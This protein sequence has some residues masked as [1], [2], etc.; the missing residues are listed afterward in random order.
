MKSLKMFH[1]IAPPAT[2]PYTPGPLCGSQTSKDSTYDT[3]CMSNSSLNCN[4]MSPPLSAAK[5]QDHFHASMCHLKSYNSGCGYSDF[6]T[7]DVNFPDFSH[8]TF[9]NAETPTSIYG[10]SCG[11]GN[12]L[13]FEAQ[14]PSINYDD[15]DPTLKRHSMGSCYEEDV[16]YESAN[17][18]VIHTPHSSFNREDVFR[19]EPEDIARL[20]ENCQ[21]E[22]GTGEGSSHMMV[23][24]TPFTPQTPYTPYPATYMSF[25]P[26]SSGQQQQMEY[27]QAGGVYQQEPQTSAQALAQ[28]QQQQ[29]MAECPGY[30]L[31]IE[32]YNYDEINCQSKEQSPCSSPP[33]D[34]WMSL[35]LNENPQQPA[36]QESPKIINTSYEATNYQPSYEPSIKQEHP[37]KLPSMMSTFGTP[38]YEPLNSFSYNEYEMSQQ[39]S[40]HVY[41]PPSQNHCNGTTHNYTPSS[42]YN[43]FNALT[44]DFENCNMLNLEKPNRD[45]KVI[46]TIDELDEINDFTNP[47]MMMANQQNSYFNQSIER[48]DEE[49]EEEEEEG[50][51]HYGEILGHE[52]EEEVFAAAATLD[53]NDEVF[54]VEKPKTV[55]Q[56][57]KRSSNCRS[58]TAS[59]Q[60]VPCEEALVDFVQGPMVCLWTDCNEEFPNQAEFVCHI[61]KKHV[62]VKR[63]EDFSCFWVDCPRRYKPFNAR[64]KLL[65]HMRV[66][67]GEKPNKCPFPGCNKAFS[68]LENLKIH[69]RSHTGERPYGCQYKGCLK[70]FSNSSDRAKHQR[71]HYDTKPYACQLPGC[72][73][74]YTDPSSLRKH[75]KNHA[76]R[77][78]NGHLG[79]RKSTTAAAAK[80]TTATT[81]TR[82]HSESSLMQ[83]KPLG[84][85]KIPAKPLNNAVAKPRSNSCSEMSLANTNYQE[86]QK[87]NMYNTTATT[88]TNLQQQQNMLND[89]QLQLA[90]TIAAANRNSMNFNE[91]SNCLV[92]IEQHNRAED[93]GVEFAA[94]AT[95]NLSCA[96]NRRNSSDSVISNSSNGSHLSNASIQ[97]IN[98]FQ[99]MLQQQQQQQQQLHATSNGQQQNE[100][101]TNLV[102]TT[103]CDMLQSAT[104]S[105]SGQQQQQE[106]QSATTPNI[107]TTIANSCESNSTD[108]AEYVSFEYVK[109]LLCETFDCMDTD[110]PDES[111][112]NNNKTSNRD[113]TTSLTSTATTAADVVTATSAAATIGA[114]IVVISGEKQKPIT[115]TT[116]AT[117]ATANEIVVANVGSHGNLQSIC[118]PHDDDDDDDDHEFAKHFDMD[119]LESFM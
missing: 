99:Q 46:W 103:A 25:T 70:A 8:I 98:E 67:S 73:K 64:Y 92:N 22:E 82:R 53:D 2:P 75:V 30:N 93:G 54:L 9:S 118:A 27:H 105:F 31:D 16:K 10:S 44:E 5:A 81:K 21:F 55:K 59:N 41:S 34:P 96:T 97:Q 36:R 40:N 95:Y 58:T 104:N 79:R 47:Q 7:A 94:V 72:T 116:S 62:D 24:Q 60:I 33:L 23:P 39:R 113:V 14:P 109:K 88:S 112:S 69:Q 61:E 108:E 12:G 52:V 32:Y 26:S 68:R 100:K 117:T 119:Y 49:E 77:N 63:G 15:E 107:E 48:T 6:S 114:S 17:A 29:Q 13:Q 101:Q 18:P 43:N 1:D 57:R 74:R 65:I 50:L 89:P 106:S 76:L 38:K 111:N 80:K 35:N 28:Q 37:Q 11:T 56:R 3:T 85:T 115:P 66:H 19:F 84:K 71:T 86:K 102:E 90:T 78:A 20:T 42:G 87:I 110:R 4:L 45:H 91:L 83:T 51:E